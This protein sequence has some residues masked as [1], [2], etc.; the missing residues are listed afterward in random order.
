MEKKNNIYFNNEQEKNDYLFLIDDFNSRCK[1]N[2]L[3]PLFLLEDNAMSFNKKA[4][5]ILEKY[6]NKDGQI[7]DSTLSDLYEENLQKH[8]IK[9]KEYNNLLT[10]FLREDKFKLF[11]HNGKYNLVNIPFSKLEE[12]LKEDKIVT[13]HCKE[14]SLQLAILSISE[15]D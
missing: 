12:L 7:E 15:K 10:K 5:K 4:L 14:C 8:L 3:S 9:Q 11:L 1:C 13:A 2:Y 6:S